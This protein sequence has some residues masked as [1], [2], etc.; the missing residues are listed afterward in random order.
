MSDRALV[1]Y[2][3]PPTR[4]LEAKLTLLAELHVEAAEL[5]HAYDEER[6]KIREFEKRWKPA[7]GKRYIEVEE[8][9]ERAALLRDQLF[10]LRAG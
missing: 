9:K 8:A 1:L 7:V 6:R 2:H 4:E 3:P 5:Q 10:E